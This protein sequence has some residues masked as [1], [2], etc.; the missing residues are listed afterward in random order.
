MSLNVTFNGSVYV[1]P[2][3]G[4]VGWGGNTTSYL[5][6]IAAGALQK[7]GGSFTLSADTDF[8]ASFGLK[9]IYY[10]SRSSNIASAGILRLNNNSD[11][12]NWRNAANSADLSLL[13]NASDELLYNGNQVLTGTGPSNYVSSITGTTNQVNAS[14][15]TGA[16]TLSLPQSINTSAAVQFGTLSLGSSIVSSSILSLTSTSLGFLPPRMTTVQRDAIVSPATGLMIYNTTTNQHNSYDGS[17]WVALAMSGGGTVNA[18]VQYQLGYY[19]AN[20][21]TISPL[22][23]TVTDANGG[24]LFPSGTALLPSISFT[25]NST[26]GMY[27]VSSNKIGW[28]VGATQGLTLESGIL[29]LTNNTN[30]YIPAGSVTVPSIANRNN[31]DTGLYFPTTTNLSVTID[32]VELVR[33]DHTNSVDF[34]IRLM[35]GTM[36]VPAGSASVPT[37]TFSGE[38]NSGFYAVGLDDLGF[39]TNGTLRLEIDT[40]NITSTL[41]VKVTPTTNQIVL[42]TTNVTTITSPAPAASRTYTIPD[43]GAPASFVMTESAQT[44]NG[45]KTFGND[46]I[47]TAQILAATGSALSPA[48]S[49]SGDTDS[50]WYE[51]AA[52]QVA[53]TLGGELSFLVDKTATNIYASNSGT[54]LLRWQVDQSGL[55]SNNSSRI[56]N[57]TGTTALPAYTFSGD[58]NTGMTQNGADTLALSTA[59]NT[60]LQI[61]SGG[62]VTQPL[63]SSFC[64]YLSSSATDVTGDGTQYTIICDG[65]RF[66]QAGDYNTSTGVF[67]A[68]ITGR[69]LFT[70][71][72]QL[73]QLTVATHTDIIARLVTSNFTY[74]SFSSVVAG[75]SI[76]VQVP[77]SVIADMDAGDTASVTI[78][79][80]G[81]SKVVDVVGTGSQG[82]TYFS[83]S[84]IN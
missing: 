56:Y 28:T 69:Y 61:S 64:A 51:P 47:T 41:P 3:T 31:I 38:D 60:A 32:G 34:G 7:T 84:L 42:G 78:E 59:G 79:V 36:S 80:D 74:F 72:I 55:S 73:V 52:N 14:A 54:P 29:D 68:P 25:S 33:F 17:A 75:S 49:F 20:G 65:E 24:L 39:S 5:I 50:G 70:V 43:A 6:A 81:S 21:T 12:I 15:S 9:S 82:R 71:M 62:Q 23:T 66:D 11:S 40:S 19:A 22:T 46:L 2:E 26:T 18:G 30:L 63:Q 16:V 77:L 4:E 1:I 48:I 76:G 13:V 37:Y 27:L 67:T 53:L 44:V 35:G 58:T 8:G 45:V 57:Y 10:K 83:G